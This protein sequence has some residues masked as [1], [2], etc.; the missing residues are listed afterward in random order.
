QMQ[1]IIEFHR[2]RL[3]DKVVRLVIRRHYRREIVNGENHL[4]IAPSGAVATM[5]CATPSY[6][7]FYIG[8][9]LV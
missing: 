8:Q 2:L 9:A 4:I 5:L 3:D 1:P 6:C 7:C